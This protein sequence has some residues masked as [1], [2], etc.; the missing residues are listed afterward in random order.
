MDGTDLQSPFCHHI[1]RYRA[2]DAA[3]NQQHRLAAAAHRDTARTLNL[4]AVDVCRI[5]AHL[6]H[7]HYIRLV[8]VHLQMRV[9]LEQVLTHS[10]TDFRRLH[11]EALV[12]TFCLHLKGGSILQLL[13]QVF[14]CGA[15]DQLKILLHH[16]GAG[17]SG[18]AKHLLQVVH[19][20]V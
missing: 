14:G 3:G 19:R 18:N 6:H 7:H 20:L 16:A 13:L 1:S 9:L 17:Q 5:I 15:A 2:V 11:R 4:A 12:R 10:G 8:N